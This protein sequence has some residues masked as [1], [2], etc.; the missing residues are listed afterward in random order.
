V[1]I[2]G[3]LG[4][5]LVGPVY[6]SWQPSVNR[7]VKGTPV[8]EIDMVKAIFDIIGRYKEI[9]VRQ[10]CY[11]LLQ[12]GKLVRTAETRGGIPEGQY[13][14]I[15][16]LTLRMRR[17]GMIL[18][19]NISDETRFSLRTANYPSLEYALQDRIRR[20][21]TDWNA[22]NDNYA[23]VDIEKRGHVAIAF[24]IT[25]S[26][27]TILNPIGGND[28]ETNVKN[29]AERLRYAILNHQQPYI[30]FFS[31]LD[32]AGASMPDELERKLRMFGVLIP[33][34]MA[35][36]RKSPNIV[37]QVAL[38]PEQVETYHLLK[39]PIVTQDKKTKAYREKYPGINYC[40]E[41]DALDPDVYRQI[42]RESISGLVN[43]FVLD[44][45]KARD[46]LQKRRA[47]EQLEPLFK[48]LREEA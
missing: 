34:D 39:L 4:L 7:L 44:S 40:C 21:R 23:E 13:K 11:Q 24:G 10:I 16:Y 18:Y 19:E 43:R 27:N 31:D 22:K 28:S 14:S 12:Q 6:E 2:D 20:F 46:E 36:E 47:I 3:K 32:P 5:P 9:A 33:P 30:L 41:I 17:S 42:I 8:K 45:A 1:N 25:D 26:W 37:Q 35:K 15:D 29:C 38:L 48:E